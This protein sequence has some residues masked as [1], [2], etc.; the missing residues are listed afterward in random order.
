MKIKRLFFIMNIIVAASILFA[1][2]YI[3]AVGSHYTFYTNT[4]V[5]DG[6]EVKTFHAD[7]DNDGVVELD[8]AYFSDNNELVLE[9]SSVAKGKT[10]GFVVLL[11][12][13]GNGEETN[14]RSLVVELTVT[15]LGVIFDT[16]FYTV[17]FQGYRV[18]LYTLFFILT[19]VL[20]FLFLVFRQYL[21]DGDFNYRMIAC[22]GLCIFIGVLLAYLVYKWANHYLRSF[23]SFITEFLYIGYILFLL[24]SPI[25]ILLSVLLAVSNIWLM[26]HEGYRLVNGLGIFFG[27]LWTL[28]TLISTGGVLLPMIFHLD[29]SGIIKRI[30]LYI[31]CYFGAMFIAT[32]VCAYLATKYRPANDRDYIIILGCG[33]REDGTLTP[34]LRGRVDAALQ[35]EKEQFEKTGKHAIFVPSGGQGSDEVISESRAMTNYLLEQGIPE[36]QILME[37]QSTNTMENMQFSK[38]VIEKHA[39]NFEDCK[40]AFATTNYHIF[41]GY[42]LARKNGFVAK[43]ISAK[44]KEYFFP[45]AFLREYIGLL[46]DRK[47]SHIAFIIMTL[48]VFVLLYYVSSI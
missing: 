19:V 3:V 40:I 43:G 6:A 42:I 18:A 24:I 8:N 7:F 12:R 2:I 37:D 14:M 33:I 39:E 23:N 34:L 29:D 26:R 44:T 35:F 15:D 30:V 47:F 45:N 5:E 17:N 11:L 13:Y 21:K 32:V 16:T 36:E 9:F 27:I 10:E 41:R 22:V 38:A 28:A 20:I 46:V 4:Y 31:S 25:M 1:A 48:I